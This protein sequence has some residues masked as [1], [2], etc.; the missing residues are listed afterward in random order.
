MPIYE[1]EC[2]HCRAQIEVLRASSATHDELCRC[3]HMMR[4]LISAPRVHTDSVA[5][6]YDHGLGAR[7]ESRS[8]RKG[9]MK[10]AGVEESG[11]MTSRRHGAKGTLF[12][13]P[14]QTVTGVPPSGAYR[15]R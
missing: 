7:V 5:P 15:E 12:S 1:Y 11:D 4:R 2:P 10:A 3:G 6:Y 13:F 8:Q 9:L 14:G